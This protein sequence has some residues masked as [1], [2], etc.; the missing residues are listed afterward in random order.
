MQYFT[1]NYQKVGEIYNYEGITYKYLNDN[2]KAIQSFKKSKR[3]LFKV[4][5][6]HRS[7][8]HTLINIGGIHFT[9]QNFDKAQK[10]FKKAENMLVQ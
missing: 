8:L 3:I 5:K 1:E 2:A 7:Y 10:Y 4:A 6:N 9:M